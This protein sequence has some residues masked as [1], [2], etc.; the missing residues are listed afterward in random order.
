MGELQH[1]VVKTK[2]YL[3][4]CALNVPSKQWRNLFRLCTRLGIGRQ[5]HTTKTWDNLTI[6]ITGI[7]AAIM[8]LTH[9]ASTTLSQVMGKTM[10]V[11]ILSIEVKG[12]Q[13][14]TL[15]KQLLAVVP[16]L[17]RKVMTVWFLT[18][19][20]VLELTIILLLLTSTQAIHQSTFQGR[21]RGSQVIEELAKK[22]NDTE[23]KR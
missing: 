1:Q 9:L 7:T 3:F 15:L 8:N 20:L 21:L 13:A 12:S 23:R 17:W 16:N 19:F 18:I 22:A 5:Q 2:M 10:S 4:H 14:D 6:E 11:E